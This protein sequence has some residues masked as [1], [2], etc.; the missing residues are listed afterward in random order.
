MKSNNINFAKLAD[1]YVSALAGN[2]ILD[3]LQHHATLAKVNLKFTSWEGS[4]LAVAERVFR[5][6]DGQKKLQVLIKTILDDGFLLDVIDTGEESIISDFDMSFDEEKYCNRLKSEMEYVDIR[7][8]GRRQADDALVFP[9]LDLYTELFVQAGLSNLDMDKGRMRGNQRIALTEMVNLTRCLLIMGDPGS[10]KTTFLRFLARKSVEYGDSKELPIFLRLA[11]IYDYS[12]ILDLPLDENVILKF[13]VEIN[14]KN[15]N[16][17]TSEEFENIAKDGRWLFLLDSLDELSSTSARE[18]IVKA[19]ESASQKWEKCKFVVTSRPLP[20]EAK[21]IPIGF[22]R[23]GI[24]NWSK[25]DIKSFLQ[26]WTKLL[27]PKASDEIHKRHWGNLLATILNRPDLRTLAK[28]AVMV[29]AMAVVNQNEA[30]LP[31]GRADLLEALIYWLIRAK[32][33]PDNLPYNEYNFIESRY[34]ELALAMVEAEGGRRRR[35]GRLWAAQQISRHFDGQLNSALEFL[36]R[37]ETDTGVL[38]RRGEGDLEFWHLS[39]QEYLAAEEIAGKTDHPEKGWWSKIE[40][41][42]DKPEWREVIIFVPLCLNRLGSERVDLFFERLAE[43]CKDGDLQSKA[44]RVALGGTILRDLSLTG[45]KPINVPQWTKILDDVTLLFGPKGSD[46]PLETRYEAA[47]AYGVG[48][49]SRLRNFEETWIPVPGGNFFFGAQAKDKNGINYDIDAAPWESPVIPTRVNDFEIRK[50]P[51]T[52]QEF[53]EF[54]LDDGYK[55][56]SYWGDDGWKWLIENGITSPLDWDEQL[57]SPNTPVTGVSWLEA[58]AYSEWLTQNDIRNIKYRLPSEAEWEYAAKRFLK[59]DQRFPWGHQ[60]TP[61]DGCEAN[62]AWTGLRKKTPV[63]IFYKCVTEDGIVDLFGNVE[64][65]CLDNW[66]PDHNESPNDSRPVRNNSEDCVVKGGSTIRFSRLCR[67]TYRSRIT[68]TKQYHPVGFRIIRHP[69][70]ANEYKKNIMPISNN[71]NHDTDLSFIFTENID[72]FKLGSES[73]WGSGEEETLSAIKNKVQNGLWLDIGAGDGRYSIPML[74]SVETLIAA[75]LDEKALKKLNYRATRK[76][77][78]KLHLVK[79]NIT[80]L[81]FKK[82]IFDGILCTGLLHLFPEDM[83]VSI[84][85]T[86]SGLLKPEGTLI[87]DFGTDI[88]RRLLN[89][90]LYNNSHEIVYTTSKALKLL[91]MGLPNINYQIQISS[92]EDDLTK[93][94]EYEYN[95]RGKFILLV[96]KKK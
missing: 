46:V 11:D 45:Y 19:L 92:F 31:E 73:L 30:K 22:E 91:E 28:N 96:G 33:R 13:F 95:T 60:V 74:K 75:D 55:V 68:K 49:D 94:G 77:K 64:E 9:I 23:V 86:L 24:D 43:S 7:G 58:C 1:S 71:V 2:Q 78:E 35:V 4:N 83:L 76:H 8:I 79:L 41:C 61:G 25:D 63:G 10:G 26:A 89:G 14:K 34:K 59:Q 51:I 3:A 54:I 37:E 47:I 42:L 80:S 44:R 40:N 52:V 66:S 48:G 50:Y 38:V 53:N 90:T 87:L 88:E 17:I 27:F 85:T 39:F 32:T 72:Y 65:W 12:K 16:V 29:T 82:E 93:T 20:I 81:A 56:K 18:K 67:A 6:A 62:F 15:G 57:L 36:N 69:N 5:A 70:S 84:L 21:S